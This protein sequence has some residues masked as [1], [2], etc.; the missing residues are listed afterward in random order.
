MNGRPLFSRTGSQRL[1]RQALTGF[2]PTG[3]FL[4]GETESGEVLR[5]ATFARVMGSPE[6]ENG[7]GDADP[8]GDR[9]EQGLVPDDQGFRRSAFGLLMDEVEVTE[10]PIEDEGHRED[11]IAR[12]EFGHGFFGVGLI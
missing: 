11:E 2:V 8:Q 12:P 3:F 5:T 7:G 1:F 4:P 6:I 9:D 10:N